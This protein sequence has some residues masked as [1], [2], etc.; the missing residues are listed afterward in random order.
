MEFKT[1]PVTHV[2]QSLL[3]VMGVILGVSFQRVGQLLNG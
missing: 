2:R 3:A 1:V